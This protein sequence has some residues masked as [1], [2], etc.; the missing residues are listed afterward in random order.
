MFRV[1]LFIIITLVLFISIGC[2]R[3]IQFGEGESES[4]MQLYSLFSNV[5]PGMTASEVQKR[6]GLPSIRN[7]DAEYQG[8]FY[9]EQWI[10]RTTSPATVL[11]FK[12][13]VLEVKDYQY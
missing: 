11:Y 9:D 5:R 13:E 1:N 4:S 7:H 8:M 2:A 6:I 3:T 10:Y 12:N